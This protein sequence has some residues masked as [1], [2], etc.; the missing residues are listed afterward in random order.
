MKKINF[1]K[2]HQ[3]S[4]M[5]DNA[6]FMVYLTDSREAEIHPDILVE[7]A[8]ELGMCEVGRGGI[9]LFHWHSGSDETMAVDFEEFVLQLSKDE[10]VRIALCAI[11]TERVELEEL[12]LVEG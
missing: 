1:E 2:L 7:I 4:F 10:I 5:L 12:E 11:E 6:N 9:V 8:Q 3:D